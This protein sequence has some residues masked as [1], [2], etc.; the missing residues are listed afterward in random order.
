MSSV[1]KFTGPPHAIRSVAFNFDDMT[2]QAKHYLDGVRGE[3]AKII[4][5]AKQEADGLRRRAEEE[6]RQA[7]LKAVEKVLDEKVSQRMQTLLPALTKVIDELRQAK[8]EWLN[9]WEKSAIHTA[10]AIAE[11][12]VRQ[13]LPQM[14]EVPLALVREALELAAGS[15]EMRISMNPTD[16][17][18]LHG[19]V[20]KLVQEC[21]RSAA[22]QVFSDAEIEPGSCRLETQHGIIDQQFS[23][24]LDRIEQ[25]LN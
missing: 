18:T 12:I 6:G 2:G 22:A 23:A 14:P 8:Q 1:I 16:Y 15:A 5:A 9:H 17:E 13:Q 25:E 10:A 4:A 3:A 20:E 11:R 19:Q 24:Q 21:A 7:A